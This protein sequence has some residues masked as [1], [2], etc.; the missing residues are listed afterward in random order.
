MMALGIF[1][2]TSKK[3]YAGEADFGHLW[4]KDKKDAKHMK[5]GD[6]LIA[7]DF[8]KANDMNVDKVSV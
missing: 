1:D 6:L 5:I 4:T 3:Y 8:F 2:K 7:I